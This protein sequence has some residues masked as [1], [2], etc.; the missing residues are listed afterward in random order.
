MSASNLVSFLQYITALVC[1]ICVSLLPIFAVYLVI[2]IYR[3]LIRSSHAD[4]RVNNILQVQ[5]YEIFK[6]QP[7]HKHA[8]K[9][10]YS[11]Q[12]TL[13]CRLIVKWIFRLNNLERTAIIRLSIVSRFKAYVCSVWRC[14]WRFLSLVGES[15]YS[16][17]PFRV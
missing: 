15:R 11:D 3:L 6:V 10:H 7:S 5:T 14:E 12:I 2:L 17:L 8:C 13:V 1:F 16:F 9:K 4:K